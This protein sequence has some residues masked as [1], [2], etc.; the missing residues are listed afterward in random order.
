MA[1]QI[2]SHLESYIKKILQIQREKKEQT[3]SNDELKNIALELGLA[4]SEWEDIQKKVKDHVKQGD[5]F[6]TYKNYEDAIKQYQEALSLNP[7]Q[8]ELLCKLAS[9]YQQKWYQEKKS[10]DKNMAIEHA[11]RCLE[12]DTTQEGAIRIISEIK[13]HESG[14]NSLQS[15]R[16]QI[17][18]ITILMTIFTMLSTGLAFIFLHNRDTHRIN[19][20]VG[21]TVWANWYKDKYWYPSEI[22][23]ISDD[24]VCVLYN[25]DSSKEC[26]TLK[27]IAKINLGAG[28]QVFCKW[29]DNYY[30]PAQIIKKDQ[31]RYYVKYSEGTTEWISLVKIRID[32][33][34][35]SED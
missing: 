3:F 10:D 7:Y 26:T 1:S 29:K 23:H 24:Q 28:S 21:D 5:G 6:Y 22:T 17:V 33:L 25:D 11:Q 4:E 32:K 19:F 9:A 27:K 18:T 35:R 34:F 13:T 31:G 20:K 12:I 30:Y 8:P 16:K 15:K 14:S 2:S